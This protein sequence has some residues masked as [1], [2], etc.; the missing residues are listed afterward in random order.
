MK[1]QTLINLFLL[2]C[3][4]FISN[5]AV[6]SGEWQHD[7][8]NFDRS[9][10]VTIKNLA[11][12]S[13]SLS[14]NGQQGLQSSAS[15]VVLYA[16]SGGD[17]EFDMGFLLSSGEYLVREVNLSNWLKFT[18]S[19]FESQ[20]T[21]ATSAPLINLPVATASH[22]T[23]TYSASGS[24]SASS[25]VNGSASASIK[26]SARGQT[27]SDSA[28]HFVSV[29]ITES[30]FIFS[31]ECVASPLGFG[32]RI[33]GM[34][35]VYASINSNLWNASNVCTFSI[36]NAEKSNCYE[37]CSASASGST[38]GSCT[39]KDTGYLRSY[40]GKYYGFSANRHY[41]PTGI[42]NNKKKMN[43][44]SI[45]N[46]YADVENNVFYIQRSS[47]NLSYVDPATGDEKFIA[48]LNEGDI[49]TKILKELKFTKK[50]NSANPT[51]LK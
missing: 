49:P 35:R 19:D 27:K 32:V 46:A 14:N 33:N 1:L 44:S 47:Y 28:S 23:E 4:C 37:Q 17:Y 15:P 5:Y 10:Q 12:V 25:F 8:P 36:F 41:T 22:T 30:P 34:L 11:G 40:N 9:G 3:S 2:F 51:V 18:K 6:S 31:A 42:V 7:N 20:F 26:C 13:T 43:I 48:Q 24:G 50:A 29:S 38:S 21:Y 16:A 39:V 45:W